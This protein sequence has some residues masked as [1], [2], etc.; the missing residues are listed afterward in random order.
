MLDEPRDVGH[1]PRRQALTGPM[2][3][4]KIFNSWQSGSGA[5]HAAP[6]P[7]MGFVTAGRSRDPIRG[8]SSASRDLSRDPCVYLTLLA[9]RHPM[10][11]GHLVGAN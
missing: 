11:Y 4:K 7:P 5:L 10:T 3:Y 9:I 6:F 8:R 2:Y 1:M